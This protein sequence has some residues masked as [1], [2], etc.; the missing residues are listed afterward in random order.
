MVESLVVALVVAVAA[1]Y[2]AWT[3]LP[4]R[5]R[6][7]LARRLGRPEPA[8]GCAGCGDCVPPRDADA[9]PVFIVRRR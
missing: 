5:W 9:Q 8:A 2:V 3:L 7:A 1:V 6:R 4:L